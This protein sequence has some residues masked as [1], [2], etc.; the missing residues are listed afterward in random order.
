M[1]K[2]SDD[3]DILG[4]TFDSK[5]TFENLRSVS[6]AASQSHGILKR[7][8]LVFYDSLLIEGC[9]RNFVL[10]VLD[11]CSAVSCSAADIYHKLL[12]RVVSAMF[13]GQCFQFFNWWSIWVWHCPSSICGSIIYAIQ[14]RVY[15][16]APFLRSTMAICASAGYRRRSGRTSVLLCASMQQNLTVRQDFYCPL[17]IIIEELMVTSIKEL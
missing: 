12:N 1:L 10:P 17:G 16:E 14:D 4:V 8:W 6:R 2:Q 13:F 11:Y 9:F 15:S 5:M 3:P 7:S